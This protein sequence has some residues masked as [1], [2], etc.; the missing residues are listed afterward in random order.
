MYSSQTDKNLLPENTEVEYLSDAELN[1]AKDFL[2]ERIDVLE[3]MV[4]N[5]E[6]PNGICFERVFDILK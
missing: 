2:Y 5:D 1:M 4:K 3:S 6:I